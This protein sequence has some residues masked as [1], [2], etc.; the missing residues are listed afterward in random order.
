MTRW[1]YVT[2]EFRQTGALCDVIPWFGFVDDGVFLA[3]S[4]AIGL[5]LS[6]DGVDY[7]CLDAT[8]REAVTTRFESALR[9]WDEH[10]H[11][12]QYVLKRPIQTV[13]QP[14]CGRRDVDAFLQSRDAFR[15]E[16]GTAR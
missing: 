4:G 13:P 11:L 12:Y 1:D 9:L 8:G 10:T 7:E 2:R 15:R 16:E 3:K 6:L 5:V 14:L